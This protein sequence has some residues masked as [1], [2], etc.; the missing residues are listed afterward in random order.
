MQLE[1]SYSFKTDQLFESV[2]WFVILAS[3]IL[4]T[5]ISDVKLWSLI[6]HGVI[7]LST[8]VLL[9]KHFPKLKNI[10]ILTDTWLLVYA[11]LIVFSTLRPG[12][13]SP[14]EGLVY[15]F[16]LMQLLLFTALS[17][18]NKKR[19]EFDYLKFESLLN[20]INYIFIFVVVSSF[21]YLGL[22]GYSDK[23]SGPGTLSPSNLGK[24]CSIAGLISYVKALYKRRVLDFFLFAISFILLLLT[25]SKGS[26]IAFLVGASAATIVFFKFNLK[27]IGLIVITMLLFYFFYLFFEDFL[28]D[29]FSEYLRNPQNLLTLTGRTLL[30]ESI[31]T[32][33]LAEKYI[34]GLGFNSTE[35]ALGVGF[36][37][38]EDHIITQSHNAY[39][40]SLINCGLLGTIPLVWFII[41]ALS[42]ALRAHKMSE[43][44]DIQLLS[45]STFGLLI[46]FAV[47]GISEASFAQAGSMDIIIVIVLIIGSQSIVSK[48]IN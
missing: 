42:R 31:F 27:S 45:C 28:F 15:A 8:C 34:L 40:E 13:S 19:F 18:Y 46:F 24:Y 12:S 4:A 5:T 44:V 32:Q 22:D 36:A 43:K 11:V 48:R 17:I 21:I 30:W 3:P 10:V 35:E 39:I 20:A 26:Y 41:R 6:Y 33:V 38:G 2:I 9:V 37:W 23:M 16:I 7:V 29:K 47:R 1:K 25:F 14:I